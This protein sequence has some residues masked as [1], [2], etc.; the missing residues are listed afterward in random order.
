METLGD[1]L[2]AKKGQKG[3]QE[4]I[5]I[6]CDFKCYKKYSWNRHLLTSKHKQVTQD[7]ILVTEKGQKGQ[8][9]YCEVCN[10]EYTSR[11][12][13]WKHRQKC[14]YPENNDINKTTKNDIQ[15]LAKKITDKDELIMF[16]IKENSEFKNMMMK[17]LEN[18]TNHVTNTNTNCMN[19]NK[20]FNL[21]FFLNETCKNAMNITDFVDSIKLQL[22]DL[23]KFGELNY[24]D[25]ISNIITTNLKAL[26][27]T[28]RPVHCTDKKRETMYIKDEDKWEKEDDNKTKLRKAINRIA[29]KNIK[30]LPKFREKYPEYKNSTSKISDKYDKMVLEVMGGIGGETSEKEDKII[31]NISKCVGIDKCI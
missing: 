19:N 24:V 6:Y 16:L 10:K 7:D 9:Y 14:K 26:D 27:I 25:G 13:L 15:E 29:D 30:L 28:Q 1:K 23:E 17:V 20:T 21:Q 4:Y 22:S 8:K 18:G 11:N 5:C 2:G 31:H 12:G 3:Q